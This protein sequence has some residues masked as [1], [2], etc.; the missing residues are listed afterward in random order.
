MVLDITQYLHY[1][2]QESQ[3]SILV[4]VILIS[5]VINAFAATVFFLLLPQHINGSR[6][7]GLWMLLFTFGF[8]MPPVGIF[9]L[10]AAILAG[11][12]LRRPASKCQLASVEAP[13]LHAL[14]NQLSAGVIEYLEKSVLK[15]QSMPSNIANPILRQLLSASSDD[16]RMMAFGMLE[17]KE[18]QLTSQ[19]QDLI[20][21]MVSAVSDVEK[22][23]YSKIIAELNWELVYS[24]LVH[25]DLRVYTLGQ[26]GIY[27]TKALELS[28][29][30]SGLIFL[31]A[32][33]FMELGRWCD[34]EEM[35]ARAIDNG[36]PKFLVLPYLA[37]CAFDR[38]DIAKVRNLIC[39]YEYLPMRPKIS[40]MID[41]WRRPDRKFSGERI[42]DG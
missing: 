6:N 31:Y 36:M 7:I 40:N 37:E 10:G 20:P 9:G 33:I 3:Q 35:F 16:I 15:L 13:H 5:M 28:P 27:A 38:G 42:N 14:S 34:A 18:K 21:L 2:Q 41:Y 19:I 22:F 32:R 17:G 11:I 23:R 24:N 12:H 39:D 8:I 30:H 26:A 25:G 4:N 1:L 29:H